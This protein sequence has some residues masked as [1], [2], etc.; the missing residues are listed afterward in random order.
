MTNTT[1][2]APLITDEQVKAALEAFNGFPCPQNGSV[3]RTCNADQMRAAL[4]AAQHPRNVAGETL[5]RQAAYH[6]EQHALEYSH[7]AQTELIDAIRNHITTQPAQPTVKIYEAYT[8]QNGWLRVTQEEYDR[9]KDKYEHR[10]RR[11]AA[12]PVASNERTACPLGCAD[13]CKA[14]LHGCPSECQSLKTR[15][16]IKEAEP[17]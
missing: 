13:Q 9:T 5:L 14:E 1:N 7:P 17:K 16:S 3:V 10:I 11:V 6:L 2:A 12:S 15:R 4:L 8:A